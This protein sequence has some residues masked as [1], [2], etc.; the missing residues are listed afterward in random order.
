M[1]WA[2]EKAIFQFIANYWVAKL[3]PFS[4]KVR[5]NNQNYLN[6]KLIRWAFLENG[7]EATLSSKA[8]VLSF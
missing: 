7:F 8:N 6:Q 2:F 3:K 4:E 5:Q 1:F